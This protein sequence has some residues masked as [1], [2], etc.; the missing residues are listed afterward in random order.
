MCQCFSSVSA[1]VLYCTPLYQ[2]NDGDPNCCSQTGS[3]PFE[4]LGDT[5]CCICCLVAVTEK[6]GRTD[7]SMQRWVE[8]WVDPDPECVQ[9]VGAMMYRGG[10]AGG[11]GGERC[12]G[13][14]GSPLFAVAATAKSC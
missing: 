8:Q 10:Q 1:A 5:D 3:R 4:P 6:A 14:G 11:T 2:Q 9:A 13:G 12:Q 7:P